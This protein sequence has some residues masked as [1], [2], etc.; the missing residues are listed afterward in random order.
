MRARTHARARC[1]MQAVAA[2]PPLA[3]RYVVT[4]GIE[5]RKRLQE[6][7]ARRAAA[8][9][10][11]AAAL[12]VV[13]EAEAAAASAMHTAT[14]AT[15]AAGYPGGAST[16]EMS[17]WLDATLAACS[18]RR[19]ALLAVPRRPVAGVPERVSAEQVRLC[20][21]LG[22]DD[23]HL[24]AIVPAFM[25]AA[26]TAVVSGKPTW[27]ARPGN[28][29]V[30]VRIR[31]GGVPPV[32][33]DWAYEAQLSLLHSHVAAAPEIAPAVAQVRTNPR[34]LLNWGGRRA[35]VR[36]CVCVC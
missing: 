17:T 27:P 9:A 3:L 25:G 33:P 21:R 18:G 24:A 2:V 11:A 20:D 28:G 35:C 36:A 29:V 6:V 31:P 7:S 19:A 15:E 22:V 4:E 10:A 1:E 8:S 23:G 32:L 13:T 34:P 12:A 5:A 16:S 14:E 26:F 30:G